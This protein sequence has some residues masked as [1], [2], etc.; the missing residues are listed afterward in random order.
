MNYADL[1]EEQ[2]EVWDIAF[3]AGT[4]AEDN[5]DAWETAYDE[6]YEDGFKEGAEAE[7]KRIQSVLQMMFESS[8]NMGHG[9]KA[10]QYRHAMELL[11]PINYKYDEAKYYED[12]RNDGF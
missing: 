4:E 11:T 9:N 1:T 7:Q 10:V 12:L 2:K 6:G 3:Q 8:L 5:S